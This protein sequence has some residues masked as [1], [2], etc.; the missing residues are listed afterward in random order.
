M[1]SVMVHLDRTVTL[2]RRQGGE[3]LALLV[4][5]QAQGVRNHAQDSQGPAG[6]RRG[7]SEPRIILSIRHSAS[8]PEPAASV[9]VRALLVIF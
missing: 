6:R 7:M 2:P 5:R 9:A 4:Q 3:R 1:H 8:P